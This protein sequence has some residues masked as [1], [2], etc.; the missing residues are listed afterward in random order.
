MIFDSLNH[1]GVLLS[2]AR[3]LHTAG[4]SDSGVWNIA[5][6]RDFIRGIHHHYAF[7][8][9]VRQDTRYFT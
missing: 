8:C 7:I 6:T 4:T 5:I 2:S 9:L 3:H 1:N